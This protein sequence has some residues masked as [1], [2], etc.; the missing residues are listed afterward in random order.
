MRDRVFKL[1]MVIALVPVFTHKIDAAGIYR[2]TNAEIYPGDKISVV[3]DTGQSDSVFYQFNIVSSN[4]NVVTGTRY[5]TMN[6]EA[7]KVKVYVTA[8]S[9]G[10]AYLSI[11]DDESVTNETGEKV[12]IPTNSIAIK[13]VEKPSTV[14]P[15]SPNKD[16]TLDKPVS[17][18]DTEDKIQNALKDEKKRKELEKAQKEAK[19]I[20]EK[21][22]EAKDKKELEEK[23][24]TPLVT[25]IEFISKSDKLKGESIHKLET[26][27]DVF[28]Y[29]Y[30]LPRR[31]DQFEIKPV[32]GK[33]VKLEFV[34]EHTLDADK[35][36]IIIKAHSG[37]IKQDIKL[38]VKK[39]NEKL[40]SKKVNDESYQVYEDELLTRFMDKFG[41]ESKK[42]EK[43]GQYFVKN[44]INLQMLVDEDKNVHWVLLDDKLNF[45]DFVSPIFLKDQV[46]FVKEAPEETQQETLYGEK[47]QKTQRKVSSEFAKIDP[48]LKYEYDYK[49][50]PFHDGEI[51]YGFDESMNEDFYRFD[52]DSYKVAAVAFDM[53]NTK[54]KRVAMVSGFGFLGLASTNAVSI[55]KKKKRV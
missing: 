30:V 23:K 55:Y 22:K 18:D 11:S 45:K 5:V 16:Q 46:F 36:E 34:K 6:P 21:E 20:L 14:K 43:I 37:E 3:V 41:F 51:V 1:L 13:V 9:V 42:D 10:T 48:E 39:N 31:I 25:E 4:P 29:E 12:N 53:E 7:S 27:K 26:K 32:A 50:W 19:E 38:V 24:K 8:K 15:T 35:K 52:N 33:D 2:E 40:L 17:K 47:Y 44:K 28:E 49:S 54:W